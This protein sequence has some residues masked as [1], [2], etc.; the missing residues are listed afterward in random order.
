MLK[1]RAVVRYLLKHSRLEPRLSA[2]LTQ[3]CVAEDS[4]LRDVA[5]AEPTVFVVTTR[6][7]LTRTLSLAYDAFAQGGREPPLRSVASADSR[8]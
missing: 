8:T 4:A 6:H 5:V 1:D 2:V 3:P 7:E